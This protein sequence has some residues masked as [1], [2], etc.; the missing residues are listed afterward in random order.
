M[1]RAP[2]SDGS[3]FV[4]R[5]RNVNCDGAEDMIQKQPE[6]TWYLVGRFSK[7]LTKNFTKILTKNLTKQF[8]KSY[9]KVPKVYK[10]GS[11]KNYEHEKGADPYMTPFCTLWVPFHRF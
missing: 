2:C 5:Y 10:K 8:T 9:E 11:K 6:G 3:G 1:Q 4:H 7:N